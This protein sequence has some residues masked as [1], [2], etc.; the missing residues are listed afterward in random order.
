MRLNRSRVETLLITAGLT[1]SLVGCGG[2]DINKKEEQKSKTKVESK[3]SKNTDEKSKKNENKDEKTGNKESDKKDNN[4]S[5]SNSKD[6][7]KNS[8]S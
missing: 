3:V 7:N 8:S 5:S 2:N 6:E 4:D 1:L